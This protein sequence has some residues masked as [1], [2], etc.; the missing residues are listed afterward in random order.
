MD[1]LALDMAERGDAEGALAGD[2]CREWVGCIFDGDSC[3]CSAALSTT[4][5]DFA[6]DSCRVWE[7][8]VA[9]TP[10]DIC[11][12]ILKVTLDGEG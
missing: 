1:A 10:A 3:C 8:G 11:S 6:G 4:E 9:K 7:R 12:G 5:K 2:S